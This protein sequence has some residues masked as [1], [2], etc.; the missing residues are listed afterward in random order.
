MSISAR[1]KKIL[2]LLVPIVVLIAFWFLILAPKRSESARLGEQ[3]TAVEQK[4]DTAVAKA[5]QLEGARNTYA[6]DYATVVRLGKA[7]PSS[8][9]MPSLLVQ[10]E[11]AAKGTGIDFD[12][13]KA[14]E[15]ATAPAAAASAGGASGAKT[16][17]GKTAENADNA[18]TSADKSSAAA[19]ATSASGSSSPST[20]AA[21]GPTG[22]TAPGLDSVPLNFTFTGSFGGLADFLHRMKRFVRVANDKISVKG[23]LMTIDSLGFKSTTF[24]TIE[25]LV[26]ASVYL[27]PKS[28]GATAGATAAGPETTPASSAPAPSAAPSGGAPAPTPPAGGGAQ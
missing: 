20:P 21:A 6:E 25:A 26:T 9:D 11:S 10:L 19:S 3:L 24:P 16:G 14:G 1:D 22:A 15:R 4:R 23:R 5:G 13:V 18:K 8:L 17:P 27:S 12:S 7:V 28:E 2:M